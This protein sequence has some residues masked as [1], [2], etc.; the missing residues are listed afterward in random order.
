MSDPL[1]AVAELA[2]ALGETPIGRVW[3][4]RIDDSWCVAVRGVSKDGEPPSLPVEPTGCM[5][6]DLRPC[7][8]AVWYNGWLAGLV[9]PG[10]GEFAANPRAFCRAVLHRQRQAEGDA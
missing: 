3:E 1:L 6:V 7:E 10:G 8:M 2:S 4:C 9:S 5:R